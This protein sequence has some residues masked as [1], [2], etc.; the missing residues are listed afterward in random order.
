MIQHFCHSVLVP[1]S[2]SSYTSIAM[3]TLVRSPRNIWCQ[4]QSQQVST[5]K[6]LSQQVKNR[7]NTSR[8][9]KPVKDLIKIS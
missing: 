3:E 9:S 4:C 2:V 5:R 7:E 6:D 8:A 1:G